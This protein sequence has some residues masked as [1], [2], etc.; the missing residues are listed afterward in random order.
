ME[1][2]NH[3]NSVCKS[4]KDH[5]LQ[6]YSSIVTC[7]IDEE[8]FHNGNMK[9]GPEGEGRL[10]RNSQIF[11]SVCTCPICKADSTSADLK[12]RWKQA[13]WSERAKAK[14]IFHL[15]LCK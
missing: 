3:L 7:A 5:A 15:R 10:D 4:A 12:E 14:K 11:F 2:A 9:G 6:G 13:I 1:A 8:G